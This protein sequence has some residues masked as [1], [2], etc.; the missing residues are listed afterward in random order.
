ML[1]KNIIAGVAARIAHLRTESTAPALITKV[2]KA[3]ILVPL[4][5]LMS[6]FIWIHG[7]LHGRF[8]AVATT[9]F[10]VKLDCALPDMIQT[11][12][13]L[14]GVWEPNLT[15]YIQQ[16]LAE[17]DTFVDIGANIGYHSLLASGCVGANGHVVSVEASPYIFSALQK[18]LAQNDGTENVRAINRAVADHNGTIPMYRGPSYN[19]GL[20]STVEAKLLSAECEV[21]TILPED[22]L[23]ADDTQNVRLVKIDVEGAEESILPAMTTFIEQCPRQTE[24]LIELTP[25]RWGNKKLS[26]DTLLQAFQDA[27]Y[28]IYKMHNAYWPWQYLW[29]RVKQPVTRLD[30]APTS[31][32]QVD[33]VLSRR[34]VTEL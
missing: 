11:Y 31:R 10:G 21:D 32:M 5:M 34:D 3:G 16:H 24:F 26:S 1:T 15:R 7:R 13:Y 2:I 17:G 4:L 30:A 27:G 12:I 25:M 33:L 22:I 8:Q 28:H 9:L 19:L 6:T 14:F 23:A 18:N 20:S 29:P